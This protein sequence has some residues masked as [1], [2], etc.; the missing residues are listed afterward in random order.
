MLKENDIKEFLQRQNINYC[1]HSSVWGVIF[2][3]KITYLA[4]PITA[5]LS[6]Q[7]HV[8]H[9]N[10]EG[11][12]IIGISNTTGK[13]MENAFDFISNNEISHITFRKKMMSYELEIAT[14]K[15]ILAYKV[16]KTMIGTPWHK[17]NLPKILQR[18]C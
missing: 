2:P 3:K 5:S 16:N 7:Y 1:E 10:Q 4:G 9:F 12:A 17:E 13:I 14:N 6:L 11:I 15:G 8:L 18:F